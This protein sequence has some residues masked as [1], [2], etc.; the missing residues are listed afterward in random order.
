MH[1]NE[2]GIRNLSPPFVK[3]DRDEWWVG[4]MGRRL[5][6]STLKQGNFATKG[7]MK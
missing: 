6:E 5:W 3:Q 2:N 4:E 1:I 7:R